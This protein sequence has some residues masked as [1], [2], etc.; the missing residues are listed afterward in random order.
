[1]LNFLNRT[2]KV[3]NKNRRTPDKRVR[4][5]RLKKGWNYNTRKYR[6]TPYRANK[7]IKNED[8]TVNNSDN[9]NSDIELFKKQETTV[10]YDDSNWD[11][12][13]GKLKETANKKGIIFGRFH[14]AGCGHCI[15]MEPYWGKMV[16][17]LPGKYFN[18]DF[19]SEYSDTGVKTLNRFIHPKRQ[20]GAVRGYPEIYMIKNR[21]VSIYNGDRNE[22][23]IK[24]WLERR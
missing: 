12:L 7:Y 19:S 15:S 3:F 13:E 17:S 5:A 6:A 11:I 18:A 8:V 16:N 22:Y 1:M 24:K 10:V 23:S 2:F 14:M 21:I 20:M 4:F 9:N